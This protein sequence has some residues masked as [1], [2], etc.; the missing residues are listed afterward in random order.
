MT[1][2]FYEVHGTYRNGTYRNGTYRPSRHGKK[3]NLK[4]QASCATSDDEIGLRRLFLFQCMGR[5]SITYKSLI[6]RLSSDA[7]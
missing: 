4:T 3:L 1:M 2:N 6:I 7:E 5:V